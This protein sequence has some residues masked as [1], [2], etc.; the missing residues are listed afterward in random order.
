MNNSDETSNK[1]NDDSHINGDT[2]EVQDDNDKNND[3]KDI[4]NKELPQYTDEQ[5][6]NIDEVALNN[7]K[8]SESDKTKE[9]PNFNVLAEYEKR[10]CITYALKLFIIK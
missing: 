3:N 1:E 10:V 8:V 6:E 4:D 7:F 2:N 9:K 5:L